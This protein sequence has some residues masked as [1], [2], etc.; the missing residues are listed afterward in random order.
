[1]PFIDAI[2]N[3]PGSTSTPS[4]TFNPCQTPSTDSLNTPG[5]PGTGTPPCGQNGLKRTQ[6]SGPF[7]VASTTTAPGNSASNDFAPRRRLATQTAIP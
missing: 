4:N 5:I 7:E 1:M 3:R 6:G 2:R